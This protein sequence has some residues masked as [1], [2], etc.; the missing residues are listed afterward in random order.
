MWLLATEEFP[1]QQNLTLLYVI[2]KQVLQQG[3]F[4]WD[5]VQLSGNSVWPMGAPSSPSLTEAA[6]SLLMISF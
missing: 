4:S 3:Q 2:G 5:K 6:L 1:K